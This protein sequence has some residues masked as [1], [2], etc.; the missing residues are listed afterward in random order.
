[1]WTILR[2]DTRLPCQAFPFCKATGNGD[3]FNVNLVSSTAAML[4]TKLSYK[5]LVIKQYLSFP[6]PI[7]DNN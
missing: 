1:M 2:D 6:K 7:L 4:Y 3:K 5:R